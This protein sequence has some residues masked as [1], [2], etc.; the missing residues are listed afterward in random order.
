MGTLKSSDELNLNI[1][2][3]DCFSDSHPMTN[4][5]RIILLNQKLPLKCILLLFWLMNFYKPQ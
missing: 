2:I 4:G 1:N 5:F 3:N